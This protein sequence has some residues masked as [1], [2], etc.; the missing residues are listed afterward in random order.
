M[1][2]HKTKNNHRNILHRGRKIYDMLKTFF[3]VN[4]PAFVED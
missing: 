2:A 4:I 1:T 3:N